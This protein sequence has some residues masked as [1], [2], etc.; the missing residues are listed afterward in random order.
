MVM[1]IDDP[2]PNP[3][4]AVTIVALSPKSVRHKIANHEAMI[5]DTHPVEV[6]IMAVRPSS[7]AYKTRVTCAMIAKPNNPGAINTSAGARP[8]G[9]PA[10]RELNSAWTAGAAATSA[11]APAPET[12]STA[13]VEADRKSTRLNSS[14]V[15]NSYAVFCMKK[16]KNTKNKI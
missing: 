12:S 5:T 10:S 9:T 14:H 13:R 11:T 2:I 3:S 7:A 16:K 8:A 1:P 4:K 15:A 6:A